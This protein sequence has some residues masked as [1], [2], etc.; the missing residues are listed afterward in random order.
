MSLRD[1][2][3]PK[4]YN[5]AER[6]N[7]TP[8]ITAT[9]YESFAFNKGIPIVIDNGSYQCRVGW[10]NDVSPR[11]QFD[12]MVSKYR[13]RKINQSVLLVGNDIYTDATAKSNAKSA[14]DGNV[15]YNFET[16]EYILDYIFFKLG[17]NTDKV[18]HP[19]LMTEP[20]C[21]PNHSRRLMSELLFE[22]YDVP[23]VCYGIDALFSFHANNLSF[24]EGG[25]VAS[26]GHTTTHVIPI[27]GRGVLEHTK[28]ISCGG[29]T[30]TD[31]ML[32]LMQL[33]YPTFPTKMTIN[34]AQHLV[35][36][37]T[38][39]AQD[40]FKELKEYSNTSTFPS[41]DRIIQFPYVPPAN[42]KTEEELARQE[43]RRQEQARR[44]KEQAAKLRIQ[45]L[46]DLE[47]NLEAYVQL[48]ESRSSM[49]KSEWI[50]R[51]KENRISDEAEL[52]EIILKTEKS[53][54][55]ARNKLLGIDEVEIKE[56]PTF[57]LVDTP[58]DQLNEAERK[59]K[60]KQVAAKSLHE[61]RQRQKEAKELARRQ[62]EEE[63]R[64]EEQRRI[65][66][67]EG[68][69]NELKNSYESQLEKVKS[70]KRKKEQ[71]LDRRSH[72]SQ[73]RMK[74][75]ANL[76]SDTPNQKRRRRGQDEDTFG[77]DDNDWSIYKEI[78][79]E[80]DAWEEEEELSQLRDYE[81][82]LLRYD[83]AFL[84]EHT[85]DAK[86]SQQNSLVFM[87][88]RGVV[89]AYDPENFGQMHQLH[90][91]VE[92]IRVPEALFQPSIIGLDQAGVVETI[93]DIVNRFDYDDQRK[94]IK[95]VFVTGGHT[96]TP[97]L[98][99]RLETS[100]R[101]ILPSDASLRIIHASDPVIDAW[102]GAALWARTEDFYKYAVTRQEYQEYGGEYLKEHRFGNV[103][104]I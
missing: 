70:L 95:S 69:L 101:S 67:F 42:E 44:L 100:L 62:Q 13:D 84:P 49:K 99:P 72:A 58:D 36:S 53:V 102:R 96:Q 9:D 35:H 48:K 79:K 90:V 56:E 64:A 22:S 3:Q 52:D 7:F 97:G 57:P 85:F 68:W 50:T 45:K 28:R 4:I 73:L 98:L 92:R 93:G 20:V 15:V 17:I 55:R 32:K 10:A 6:R 24:D 25:I 11:L 47:N 81:H 40:Y 16:M 2:L 19:V 82:K 78:S 104:R 21:N 63:E 8:N 51:L 38:Y 14:F 83:P 65:N 77:M 39:V 18:Y 29:L 89:P 86:N 43:E 26:S 1:N 34:Q 75:I 27:I 94:M 31:Y 41:K 60:K 37:F 88:T 33:K 61:T 5:I 59:E 12:S 46:K 87:L 54:Q 71:L 80:E 91:N 66:D 103:Y 30:S 23:S 76:A 74:S